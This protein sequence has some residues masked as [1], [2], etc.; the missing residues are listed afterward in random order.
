LPDYIVRSSL[1]NGVDVIDIDSEHWGEPPL[2][3][4]L[5]HFAVAGL[6]MPMIEQRSG[7]SRHRMPMIPGS[8]TL[9]RPGEVEAVFAEDRTKSNHRVTMS[10]VIFGEGVARNIL[11][12]ANLDGLRNFSDPISGYLLGAASKLDA[13]SDPLLVDHITLAVLHRIRGLRPQTNVRSKGRI[14][15]C[16]KF[17]N[18]RLDHKLTLAELAG[19]AA[20]SQYH[21]VRTFKQVTGMTPLAYVTGKRIERAK[22]LMASPKL[23]MA[24]ISLM[25]GFSSQSQFSTAFK[26][27]TGL[28]PMEYRRVLKG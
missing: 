27:H 1:H 5:Y 28:S 9:V 24:S 2:D 12:D 3:Q 15:R 18:E 16:L 7:G 20:M 21:F 10:A 14:E 22:G 11:D 4:A 17:V 25:C 8:L 13:N 23:P 26:R 19:I 6:D